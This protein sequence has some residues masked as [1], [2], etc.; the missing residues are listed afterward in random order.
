MFVIPN[1]CCHESKLGA[2]G[3]RKN[4]DVRLA[5][6]CQI[7]NTQQAVAQGTPEGWHP[8]A[9]RGIGTGSS[10]GRTK[11]GQPATD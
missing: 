7:I 8:G 10:G 9:V 5:Q 6:F 2:D 4:N 11:K 1:Q 3:G